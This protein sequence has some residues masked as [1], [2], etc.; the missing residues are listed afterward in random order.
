MRLFLSTR[1]RG[2]IIVPTVA[3]QRGPTGT[4]VYQVDANSTVSVKPVKIGITEGNDVAIAEGLNAGD[5]VVV[6]GAEKLTEGMQVT[7]HQ[8]K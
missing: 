8:G 5:Q 4:F 3:I 6:D 2:L 1:K 7:I